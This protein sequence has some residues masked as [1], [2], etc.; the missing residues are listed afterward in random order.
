[1]KALKHEKKSMAGI[2]VRGMSI[3]LW[4]SALLGRFDEE[5]AGVSKSPLASSSSEFCC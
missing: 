3:S 1:M 4:I 2:I 5:V